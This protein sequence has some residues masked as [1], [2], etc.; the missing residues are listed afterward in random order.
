MK[1][2]QGNSKL[3]QKTYLFHQKQ[4][5]IEALSRE[6]EEMI[7]TNNKLEE[8]IRN[9]C[10]ARIKYAQQNE[11]ALSENKQSQKQIEYYKLLSEQYA[12]NT[13][14]VQRELLHLQSNYAS[15]EKCHQQNMEDIET[16]KEA[17]DNQFK[18]LQ[19]QLN[20]AIEE[21]QKYLLENKEYKG[22]LQISMLKLEQLRKA[23]E[24]IED[25]NRKLVRTI[26]NSLFD[27]K[28]EFKQKA[29]S[30]LTQNELFQHPDQISFQ[31][32][33]SKFD[34]TTPNK[35]SSNSKPKD[36]GSKRKQVYESDDLTIFDSASKPMLTPTDPQSKKGTHCKPSVTTT[37]QQK[38]LSAGSNLSEKHSTLKKIDEDNVMI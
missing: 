1:K 15:L 35:L 28:K 26:Q 17:A 3:L 4:K 11:L 21:K 12:N 33:K 25:R 18:K 8:Q 23:N 29:Y 10:S 20:E 31:I 36:D 7:K 24:D 37:P 38:L 22:E 32:D 27:K 5:K 16:Q 6:G 2:K 34:M 9:E 19:L 30:T 13:N 14:E